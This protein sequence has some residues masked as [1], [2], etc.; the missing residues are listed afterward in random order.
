MVKN[1]YLVAVFDVS[2]AMGFH[3]STLVARGVIRN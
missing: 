3:K 1:V 2:E